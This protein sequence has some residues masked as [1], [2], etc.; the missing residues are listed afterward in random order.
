MTVSQRAEYQG[1]GTGSAKGT[2]GLFSVMSSS[3]KWS[4]VFTYRHAV[5][6]ITELL[7]VLCIS[8]LL[9]FSSLPSAPQDLWWRVA[10]QAGKEDV[11]HEGQP[12]RGLRCQVGLWEGPVEV[13]RDGW[14]VAEVAD[15]LDLSLQSTALFHS[16]N[17]NV[18]LQMLKPLEKLSVST[19]G[20]SGVILLRATSGSQ[21]VTSSPTTADFLSRWRLCVP[22]CS[23]IIIKY[24]LWL[25]PSLLLC[26][27]SSAQLPI[28]LLLVWQGHL[29]LNAKN[30][31]EKAIKTRN[32]TSQE[33]PDKS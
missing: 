25:C 11:G 4:I 24:C 2:A 16:V 29:R 18:A 28:C 27:V 20:I 9:G 19:V 32:L 7:D 33:G 26:G 10:G 21:S 31:T 5:M 1:P 15:G 17:L 3:F 23:H 8:L 22:R 13:K 14:T 30:G 12:R 6:F